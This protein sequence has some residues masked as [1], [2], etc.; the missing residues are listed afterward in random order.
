MIP[1]PA[2][3]APGIA[4]HGAGVPLNMPLKQM[5]PAAPYASVPIPP[6]RA[7]T[8]MIVSPTGIAVLRVH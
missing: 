3:T 8:L 6:R 4:G 7:N 1:T 2:Q 5:P